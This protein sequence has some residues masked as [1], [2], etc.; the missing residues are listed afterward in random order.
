METAR[1]WPFGVHTPSTD[2]CWLVSISCTTE[3]CS[4][5][6]VTR[7]IDFHRS[8]R[9]T[10]IRSPTSMRESNERCTE[11]TAGVR[12]TTLASA[13]RHERTTVETSRIGFRDNQR[14]RCSVGDVLQTIRSRW[15]KQPGH[16][17]VVGKSKTTPRRPVTNSRIWPPV[18]TL[19]TCIAGGR[20]VVLRINLL[21]V[22]IRWAQQGR[23]LGA[24]NRLTPNSQLIVDVLISWVL[25][26]LWQNRCQPCVVISMHL[27]RTTT[28]SVIDRLRKS[29]V[30]A[31]IVLQCQSQLTNVASALHPTR[32]FARSLYRWQQQANQNT[33]DRNDHQQLNQCET[34]AFRSLPAFH[35]FRPFRREKQEKVR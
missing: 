34:L 25:L 9:A 19:A 27:Q 1:S 11:H 30:S 15:S 13:G 29:P 23:Y 7:T 10:F 14:I 31:L 33:D 26:H 3:P 8:V 24:N 32:S 20:D 22:R 6:F 4:R 35:G 5:T 16:V 21:G 2:E 18:E 28:R 12:R 17:A